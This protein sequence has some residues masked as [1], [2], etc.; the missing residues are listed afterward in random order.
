[1]AGKATA[2]V[3]TLGAKV[4]GKLTFKPLVYGYSNARVRA[5]QAAYVSDA[6]LREMLTVGSVDEI[7]ELL[8]RTTYKEDLIQLSLK[9]RGEELVELALSANF[10]RFAQKLRKSTPSQGKKPLEAL[11]SRWDVRNLKTVILGKKLGKKFDEVSPLLVAAGTLDKAGLQR[12]LEAKDGYEFYGILRASAFGRAML[13]TPIGSIPGL[14]RIRRLMMM[15]ESQTIE[16]LD[17]LLDGYYFYLTSQAVVPTDADSA[18]VAK[19]LSAEADAKNLS[20]VLR[21]RTAGGNGTENLRGRIV[22]GGAIT[23]REWEALYLGEDYDS[24]LLHISKALGMHADLVELAKKGSISNIEI[25]L[26]QK[27]AHESLRAMRRMQMSLGAIVGAIVLKEQE[28][29]N[30]RKIVRGKALGLPKERITQML[31]VAE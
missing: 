3:A 14:Q 19:M 18:A 27:S 12:M 30:I 16:G 8:E 1:M 13:D 5:M 6:M 28:M 9:F 4:Q 31:V 29:S 25:A 26:E 11:L 24:R 20:T 2:Y 10:A 22:P 7:V 15:G 17:K 23:A 21:L